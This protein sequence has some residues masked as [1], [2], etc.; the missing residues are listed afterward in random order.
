MGT[1]E[2]GYNTEIK[3]KNYRTV[4]DHNNETGRG[5][6]TC[7]FFEELDEILGH[8]P[9]STP[10]VL[11]DTGRHHDIDHQVTGRHHDTRQRHD[12]D[13][14]DTGQHHD[15]G[16]HHDIDHQVT[17][18]HHD[19]GQRHDI[20]HLDTGQHHDTGR[21]HDIDGESDDNTGQEADTN[22]ITLYNIH[23]HY[24][25]LERTLYRGHCMRRDWDIPPQKIWASLLILWWDPQFSTPLYEHP[26]PSQKYYAIVDCPPQQ[27]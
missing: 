14:L 16:R 27:V 19:T 18:R 6:K 10:H 13:H 4:K 11:V 21:H 23:C 3:L 2:I 20:D 5:R 26:P 1:K 12:I 8:R 24:I 9:A 22:G 25:G 7:K 15:T 17:G